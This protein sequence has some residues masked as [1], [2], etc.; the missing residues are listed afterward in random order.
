MPN[1][2]LQAEL[3]Q[4][5]TSRG[6]SAILAVTP[7]VPSGSGAGAAAGV[8]YTQVGSTFW[9]NVYEPGGLG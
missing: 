1:V 9:H 3:T 6:G 7:P 5:Q 4:V 2:Q 8:M